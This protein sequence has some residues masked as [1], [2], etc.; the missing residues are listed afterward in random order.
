MALQNNKNTAMRLRWHRQGK[1]LCVSSIVVARKLTAIAIRATAFALLLAAGGGTQRE[2]GL[3][4]VQAQTYVPNQNPD[5]MAD[6]LLNRQSSLYDP[7][8]AA[9]RPGDGQR[10]QQNPPDFSWPHL[11]GTARYEVTLTYPDSQT[12]TLSASRNWINWDEVLPPGNYSWQVQAGTQSSNVR[13]FTV[14]ADSVPFIVPDVASV[15]NQLLAKPHPRGLPDPITLAQMAGQRAGALVNLRGRVNSNLNESLPPAGAQGEG[16]QYGNKALW[17]LMAY[18]YDRTDTYGED[19]KRRVLNLASWDPRGPTALDDQESI[20]FAWVLTLG[21]DWLGP[22]LTQ[23]EKDRILPNLS[24]RIGD[25]YGWVTGAN[26]WPP[27]SPAVPPPLWLSPRDSHRNTLLPMVAVMSAL[28]VGDLPEANTWVKDLLPFALNVLSP[29][30][31]EEAGN[32]NGTAYGM[33]EV[34]A[35]LSTWY[36]LR[37]ATC[38]SRQTCVDLAQKAWV[39]NYEGFLAYFVP[40][41]FAASIDV[42]DARRSDPGTPIG[43]F[44]DGFA[45]T[46]LFEERSR[47]GKGYTN[48]APSALGCWYASR[49]TG[50]DSTRIEYLMSPPNTCASTAFPTGTS[51]SLYLPSIG[52]LAMHSDLADL[53]RTSVYF[54]SSPPPFGAYNHQS[55]DQN[56]FVINSG[57]Q[58]LAIESGYYGGQGGDYNSNQ[59]QWWVKRTKSKNAITF[60]GGQGQIAFEHQPNPYQLTNVHY[61]SITQRQSTADYDIVTGDATDAYNGALTKAVRS[62]VYLRP[63]TILVYDNLGSSTARTW[64]WNIHALNPFIV[65][66]GSRIQITSGTQSLCADILAGPDRQFTPINAPDYDSWGRSNEPVNYVS[67]APSDPNAATQYHGKFVSAQPSTTAEIIALLRVGCIATA[68]S[69]TKTD[70]TWTVQIGDRTVTIDANG[71]VGVAP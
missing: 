1:T 63:G 38:G 2:T 42:H 14:S 28:L 31:G 49:L 65:I 46:Q 60:D 43:L 17:S 47:F 55:A 29:W 30:S 61:G 50:E 6:I 34:G 56:A 48:F 23:A 62:L 10:V 69:A 18:V 22:V 67:A 66:D 36:A 19:A 71:T 27:D 16:V 20:N 44:G 21:Y 37:W 26:G 11:S 24:T 53:D 4:L 68:A 12:K 32:A 8:A 41:T 40:P 59:W 54:K 51:N 45:E 58:R 15:I 3:S 25:L 35:Q 52:W 70:G 7:G 9:V 13:K 33:W 57:G 39:R 5:W 64:E